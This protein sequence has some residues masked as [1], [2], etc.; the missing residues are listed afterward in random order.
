MVHG[1]RFNKIPWGIF[2]IFVLLSVGIGLSGYF[3]YKNQK[4]HLK[5]QMEE[6]LSAISELKAN[7]I[8]TWRKERIRNVSLVSKSPF[9]TLAIKRFIKNPDDLLLRKRI[10][11]FITSFKETYEFQSIY[12]I[13]SRKRVILSSPEGAIIDCPHFYEMVDESYRKDQI[14]LTDLHR[15]ESKGFIHIGVVSPIKDPEGKLRDPIAF[16]VFEI[17]P[18]QFLYPLIQSWPVLSWSAETILVRKEG[19]KIVYLNEL[20]HQKGT[21]LSLRFSIKEE[22]L[23]AA[24]AGRGKVGIVEGIDYRGKP[25]IAEIRPIPDSLWILIAKI[26]K[27]EIFF[28]I[29]ERAKVISIIVGILII[30]LG[31]ILLLF[32]SRQKS[33]YYR[34]QLEMELEHKALAQ[35]FDYL[36][37][38]ANDIILLINENLKIIEANERAVTSYGYSY[39]ELIGMDIRELRPPELRISFGGLVN[40]IEQSKGLIFETVHQRKDGTTFPVEVSSRVIDM[41]GRKIYQSIIRDITERKKAEN[42][43]KESQAELSAIFENIPV[44]LLVVDHERR[45]KKFNDMAL[46]FARRKPEEVIGLRGGEALRCLHSLDDP[47]GCG[48]G[49]FC[50][51]CPVRNTILETFNTGKSYHRV[52]SKLPLDLNGKTEEIHFFLSTIP[53]TI[54]NEQMV[55]VC[56]ED[57][58]KL[59]LT[60]EALKLSEEKFLKAFQFSPSWM[61]IST[62]EEG[63]Y[64]EVNEAFLKSIGFRREEVIGKT[65]LEL[66]I[67]VDP[68]DRKGIVS[69]I[70]EKGFVLNREVKRRKKSGEILDT[71]FSG[72]LIEIEGKNYILSSTLDITERKKAE[73]ELKVSE[74]RYRVLVESSSDGILVVDTNRNIISCN[75][76]FCNLF[77]YRK[78]EVEGKSA[79]IIHPSE[80]SFQSFGEIAYP[81]IARQGFFRGEWEVVRKDG[82]RFL[83]EVVISA[84][85]SRDSSISRYVSIIRDITERRRIENEL[86]AER[87]KFAKIVDIA[88]GAVCMFCRNPNGKEYFQYASRYVEGVYGYSPEEL[89]KDASIINERINPD[90]LIRVRNELS[91]SERTLSPWQSEFRYNHPEKGEIWVSNRFLPKH[92]SDGTTIWYGF[93]LDITDHKKTELE[94][95]STQEQLRQA[96][97][98]EAIGRLAGGIAHDFNNILSVIKGS[99][100]L[101][102]LD[103]KEGDPL[104][105]NIKDIEKAAD[106]A[107]DL[108]RQL[109]AFSRK[110]IMEIKVIDLNM[111]IKNLDKMLRR[112]LGE[113][114]ELLTFLSEPIG[115]VRVDPGQMEQVIMNLVVNAR[116]AMP[117]G[118][119]LTIE[120]M[121]IELDDEYARKHIGVKPGFYVMLSISDTGVGMKP[122]VK[123]RIFEPF[124]TTKEMGK[125]TGLGLSTVYGIVKQSE[126]N[127]WVYSELGKGTTF[128]IYLPQVQEELSE[129]KKEVM[130]GEIPYGNETILVIEDEDS[131]RKL[132]VRLLRRQGYKVLEA[133]GSGKAFMLCERYRE[134]IHL[135]LTDV[136]MPEM[137]GRELTEHLN[138]IHPEAKILYMSGYTDNVILHHGILEKGIA[139][140]QKPFTLEILAK[141][142]REVLDKEK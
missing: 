67:W 115:K 45:I 53:L 104:Y 36:S 136:V 23:P 103:L 89:A 17:D 43:L 48:F 121:N 134:P 21:A 8:S 95:I 111:L 88:P 57:I 108:T 83:S 87:D 39:E 73:N 5:R 84:M 47:K 22:K 74:E 29:Y 82:V 28:P 110:Q 138:R 130:I 24:M 120:T 60:E 63:R 41:D 112:I 128:K 141:K 62:L 124:F 15:V 91:E 7:Q 101:S 1:S 34:K 58:T 113:D 10:L 2:I 131:V 31:F 69:E 26:D 11:N 33:E 30:G 59:K 100:Q 132:A 114:I 61:V 81:I 75:M 16:L 6:E 142:V 64:I 13:D 4:A 37:R 12:L 97:K 80:E 70:K 76:G 19:D 77:G 116:D 52:E 90:D 42:L 135:I 99:S 118:G 44:I 65:S 32:W 40:L 55:L 107:A 117:N 125:G 9:V 126:G 119:K 102:L 25:V 94:L 140:I 38:Y 3:Y 68:E 50:E 71:L 78:D 106:R 109:L 72:I 93:V 54:S 51:S 85:R 35:R 139:F 56:I 86:R 122:E 129:M 79:R 133:E 49:P 92:E 127:I 96:Q 98:M 46:Q 105:S 27:E 20:R 66:N 18:Q 123:E 14:L 137:S